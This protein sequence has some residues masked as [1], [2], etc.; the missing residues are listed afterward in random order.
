[1]APKGSR[2]FHPYLATSE[3]RTVSGTRPCSWYA[4]PGRQP[5]ADEPPPNRPILVIVDYTARTYL[6]EVKPTQMLSKPFAQATFATP[7]TENTKLSSPQYSPEIASVPI[8]N[9]CVRICNRL[10]GTSGASA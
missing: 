8:G 7:R 9:L 2:R 5:A 3:V 6:T 4:G 10:Y 1:M